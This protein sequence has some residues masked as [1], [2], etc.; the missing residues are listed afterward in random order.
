MIDLSV[1]V[2][3]PLIDEPVFMEASARAARQALTWPSGGLYHQNGTPEARAIIARWLTRAGSDAADVMILCNGAQQA[4]HLAFADLARLSGSIA[5]EGATFSGAIAAA[6][7]LGLGWHP[8]DHDD[9]GMLPD[10]LDRVLGETGCRTVFTTPICQNPLGFETGPQ[11]R[12][13]IVQVCRKHDAYIVEDDI[14]AIYAAKG[15]VTYR[16]LAPERTY[17]LTSLSKCLTPLPRVGILVPAENH[18]EDIL[19]RMRAQTFGVSPMALEFGC[20]LIELGADVEA[21]R[22]LRAEAR[23]R[24]DLARQIL[25]LD[26]VPM[27]GGAPHIWL[28]MPITQARSF[29]D[30]A[31]ARGVKVTRPDATL[32]GGEKFGGVRLCI[33]APERAEE[34]E[35]ALQILSQII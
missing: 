8:I 28:P 16:Q 6:A 10:E 25:R 13:D 5:S 11:R 24:M 34:A 27:P 32:I 3:P 2:P 9:E 18:R 4:L 35:R 23:T 21:A 31:E 14:Y 20:A 30:A 7:Q 15:D 1:N 22:R 26:H 12:Q 19:R 33:L 29:S 17:Y